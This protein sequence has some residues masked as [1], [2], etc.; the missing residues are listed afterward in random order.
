MP[1]LAHHV[2]A[3]ADGGLAMSQLL[4][5]DLADLLGPDEIQA[6]ARELAERTAA[7]QDLPARVTDHV[8]LEQVAS[9]TRSRDI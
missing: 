8:L 3:E 7:S 1:G 5:A 4:I 2:V 6:A 9:L